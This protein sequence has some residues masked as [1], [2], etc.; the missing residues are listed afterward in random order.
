MMNIFGL[1]WSV[2]APNCMAVNLNHSWTYT[3]TIA[4]FGRVHFQIQKCGLRL[5]TSSWSHYTL[6]CWIFW[7]FLWGPNFFF[8]LYIKGILLHPHYRRHP[9]LSL[10][11]TPLNNETLKKFG[12]LVSL[13]PEN[14]LLGLYRAT[15]GCFTFVPSSWLISGNSS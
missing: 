14:T 3:P 13:W 6:L 7:K 15:M 8:R 11:L 1:H 4:V 2:A 5:V 9:I 10:F 12:L